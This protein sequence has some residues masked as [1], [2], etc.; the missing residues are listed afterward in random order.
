MISDWCWVQFSFVWLVFALP[1]QL[2][3]FGAPVVMDYGLV[4]FHKKVISCLGL[5]VL[6]SGFWGHIGM[7]SGWPVCPHRQQ[8]P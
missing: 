4:S 7:L 5:P 1:S 6:L 2:P 8:Y 3:N